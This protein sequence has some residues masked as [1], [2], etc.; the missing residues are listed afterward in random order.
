METKA[1]ANLTVMKQIHVE[2]V[3][4]AYS[5]LIKLLSGESELE[6]EEATETEL[7]T[8]EQEAQE[9]ESY[10]HKKK[11]HLVT[12]IL[13]DYYE[14]LDLDELRWR[15]T[16]DDIKKAYKKAVLKYHPDKKKE[17]EHFDDE[18]FKTVQIAYETL[19]DPKKKR[20]YDSQ[21]PFD[22]SIPSA[23]AAKKAEDFYSIFGEAF[24]RNARWSSR[25]G[26]P[27]LGDDKTPI[28]Q[29]QRFYNFW[30]EFKSWRD[31]SFLDEYDSKDA[32]SREEKRW[33][34]RKNERSQAKLKREEMQRIAKLVDT[35]YK[36]DPRIRRVKEEEQARKDKIKKEKEEVA[37]KKR[38][39]AEKAA[40]EERLRKEE[41][42]RKKAEE[43]A[44]AK[45]ERERQKNAVKKNRQ[46][47]RRA[48]KENGFN[49]DKLELILAQADAEKLAVICAAFDK[50]NDA[51]KAALEAEIQALE[52][53]KAAPSQ[54]VAKK[55]H[56]DAL[57]NA[58][59][60]ADE[61]SLLAKA[62]KRYPGGV[63]NRWELISEFIG[64]KTPQ[65]VI[66][67]VKQAKEDDLKIKGSREVE[68]QFDRFARE[69]DK[70]TVTA[71]KP[72][73]VPSVRYEELNNTNSEQENTN[74]TPPT[75]AT[76]APTAP[77]K[78]VESKA[79]PSAAP[80]AESS[81]TQEWSADQQ[82]QLETALRKYP[83]TAG[84]DRWDKIASEVTGKN[85]QDCILRFKYL[86]EIVKKTKK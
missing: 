36:V 16:Q 80:S 83:A 56:V 47:L 48:G 35:A 40:E 59:W 15:A 63:T 77:V 38:E 64:T 67:K 26:V 34:E 41:E 3:G 81:V 31:F 6:E 9:E 8:D 30:F 46:K 13:E 4:Q 43:A 53:A 33:M 49:D 20:A 69:K 7:K 45:A 62:I 50:S 72:Q 25:G 5:Q 28:E 55:L 54:Q 85:K 74:S 58:I 32:E 19:S 70:K 12:K 75:S 29:V 21:G 22:D 24:D 17:G 11:Q 86:V 68:S 52:Q 1:F 61:L 60:N 14:L 65:D 37:K 71:K 78:P 51:G 10:K 84:P 18:M 73:Y 44:A 82:K 39:E 42:D 2:P 66:A 79:T 57:G 27:G 23:D 76:A